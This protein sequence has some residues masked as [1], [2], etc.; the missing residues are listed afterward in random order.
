MI[1]LRKLALALTAVLAIST[2]PV[3]AGW[4]LSFQKGSSAPV[5][6]ETA[7]YLKQFDSYYRGNDTE[8]VLYLTFD[9]G[10][11][12]GY[13]EPILDV[14]NKHQ[15]PA[16]FFLTGNYLED[17]PEII[18]RMV[19][20]GHIV[21]NHTMKHPDM[22]TVSDQR[23]EAELAGVNQIYQGI[24]GQ[25][26]PKY[27]RPPKG[28]YSEANLKLAQKLGYKTV[29]WSLAYVDWDDDKQPSHEHAYDKLI[30]RIHEGAIILL[31]NTS[32]TNMEILDGL[33]TKYQS[34]GYVFKSLDELPE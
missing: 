12:N 27:Y 26:I 30:P 25:E 3:L 21:G 11:E 10:Y 19:N 1:N 5:A 22:T 29:F 17:H 24:V 32:K 4:G 15:A 20:E 14:L 7:E 33:L 16:A 2:T 23:F 28:T 6:A 9:A 13:T 31:H 8:K 18:Q 34:L